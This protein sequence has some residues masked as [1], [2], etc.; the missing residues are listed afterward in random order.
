MVLT[1]NLVETHPTDCI[2]CTSVPTCNVGATLCSTLY[3]T[4]AI[5]IG[6]LSCIFC[7]RVYR[8]LV[9]HV[10]VCNPNSLREMAPLNNV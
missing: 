9:M 8:Y 3:T 2:A 6:F 7:V 5:L 4:W 10:V 1:G